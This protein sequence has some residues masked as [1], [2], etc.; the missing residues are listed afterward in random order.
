MVDSFFSVP[1]RTKRWIRVS[2]LFV[3][4]CSFSAVNDIRMKKKNNKEF[5]RFL[6]G[7]AQGT[8]KIHN[9]DSF[10]YKSMK[11]GFFRMENKISVKQ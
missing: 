5:R 1:L 10:S 8:F 7:Q 4:W 3:W 2:F 11:S 9:D 6:R